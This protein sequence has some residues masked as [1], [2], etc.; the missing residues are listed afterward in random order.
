MIKNTR[1]IWKTYEKNCEE[2]QR[3]SKTQKTKKK[4]I[5]IHKTLEKT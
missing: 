2:L 5:K 4:I 1:N 3:K